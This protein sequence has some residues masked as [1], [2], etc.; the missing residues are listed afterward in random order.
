VDEGEI[1]PRITRITRIFHDCFAEVVEI[2]C[3]KFGERKSMKANQLATLVLRLLGIY[4]LIEIIPYVSVYGS[5]IF[6]ERRDLDYTV[7]SATTTAI[8]LFV[9]W[10]GIGISLIVYSVPWGQKLTK[11]F[12]E[13]NVTA[14]SF[15]QIQALAFAVAGILILAGSLPQL[16][17]SIYSL[18]QLAEEEKYAGLK[19]VKAIVWH[20]VLPAVGTF[21]KAG[22]GFWMFFGARGFANFWRSIRNFG[23]PKPPLT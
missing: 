9:F 7:N 22:L 17:N 11:N 2:V 12:V 4:C 23:T 19:P 21:L 15:E 6:Y 14:L 20:T 10:L 8:L 16:F 1:K 3:G 13:S 18:G 5:A